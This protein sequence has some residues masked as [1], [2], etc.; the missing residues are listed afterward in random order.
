M[1]IK[2]K[3]WYWVARKLPKKLI[4]WVVIYLSAVTTTGKY[5]KTIVPEL[6]LFD[7]LDRFANDNNIKEDE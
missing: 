1:T 5:G 4:Y 3:L 6:T 7:A 2:Q